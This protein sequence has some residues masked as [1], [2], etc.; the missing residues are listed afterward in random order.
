MFGTPRVRQDDIDGSSPWLIPRY[1]GFGHFGVH[2]A[3]SECLNAGPELGRV[4]YAVGLVVG[5][6][7]SERYTCQ[8]LTQDTA[9]LFFK[10]SEVAWG[11]ATFDAVTVCEGCPSEGE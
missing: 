2:A 4:E 6:A 9:A 8:T 3:E 5:G 11:G 10:Q 1:L 7:K